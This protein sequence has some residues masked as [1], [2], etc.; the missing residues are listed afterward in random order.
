MLF[1]LL[2]TKKFWQ[3]AAIVTLAAIPILVYATKQQE[4]KEYHPRAGDEP[5]IFDQE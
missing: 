3:L 2:T 4:V 1:R 5:D